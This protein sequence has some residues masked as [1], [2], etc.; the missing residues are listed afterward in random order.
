MTQAKTTKKNA[1]GAGRPAAPD[2]KNMA[3][4]ER[5]RALLQYAMDRANAFIADGST[6]VVVR[7][8]RCARAGVPIEVP[9]KALDAMSGALDDAREAIQA[10]YAAPAAKPQQTSR[11]EL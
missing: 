1:P 10:A 6:S 3:D 7:A 2:T 11:V 8:A 4:D 5:A 9:M